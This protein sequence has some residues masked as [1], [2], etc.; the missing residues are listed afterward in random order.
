MRARVLVLVFAALALV[1]LPAGESAAA[2][3]QPGVWNVSQA[4]FY[5]PG[6]Y[7]GRTACGGT[8]TPDTRG[9]AHRSLSCG[10][11][12]EFEWHGAHVVVSVIDR[13]PFGS[14]TWDLTA[15]TCRDLSASGHDRCMTGD[16]AWR[17]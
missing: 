9:V 3:Y 1:L 2:T 4:T 14:A 8:L 10:H 7:G 16:I 12:V 17:I 11:L 6:L 13:G 15:A 5:G